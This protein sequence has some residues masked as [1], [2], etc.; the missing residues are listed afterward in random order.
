MHKLELQSVN[1]N[2]GQVRVIHDVN[3]AVKDG[4]FLVLVGPSGCGK[5]TV[6]RMIAGLEE[7]TSG[8]L[9]LDGQVANDWT[10]VTRS[11]AMVFQSYALYPNMTV[12][13]NI[14]FGLEQAKLPK[15]EIKMRVNEAVEILKLGPLMDRRPSQLSGGQSQRVAIGRAIVRDPN[16]FLFDEP[17]SNLDAELRVH[18]RVELAAL[19]VR[20]GKTMIYVTHDQVEAM[21]L[22]DRIAIFN[23]GRIEQIGSPLEL[24]NQPNNK[25]VA[26]F[27]GSPHMNVLPAKLDK[28]GNL[29][30]PGGE[31]ALS[32]SVDKTN[33]PEAIS[34]GLRPEHLSICSPDKGNLRGK[35]VLTEELGG[36]AFLYVT[37]ENQKNPLIVRK[38]G[39]VIPKKGEIVG[40]K[41]PTGSVYI[42]DEENGK[43]ISSLSKEFLESA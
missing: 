6:L 5:S 20:L 38:S 39:Q 31:V 22:A 15:D 14:A 12:A 4:E 19:H 13:K 18:M 8:D 25:F 32:D 7:I 1:K 11:I 27:I 3:L 2:F 33:F 37:L 17:L 23:D 24:Y 43:C 28:G 16:I 40:L 34:V 21:T 41:V 26:G 29:S 10:P 42:F 9:I 30:L 35:I 36:E